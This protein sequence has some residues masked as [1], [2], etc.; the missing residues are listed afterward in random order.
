MS[1]KD[2]EDELRPPGAGRRN[3][4]ECEEQCEEPAATPAPRLA[5]KSKVRIE[6]LQTRAELNGSR[7]VVLGWDADSGRYM[8]RLDGGGPSLKLRP[9]CVR[10]TRET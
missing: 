1:E 9:E 10:E 2:L 5:T 4:D 8:V 7:A 3:T 6:G